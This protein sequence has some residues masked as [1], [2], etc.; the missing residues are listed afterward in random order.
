MQHRTLGRTGWKVSAIGLGTWNI[1][2]QWGPVSEDQAVDTVRAAIDAGINL[3]DTADAYGEPPGLS[4]ELV[5]RAI[6]GRRDEVYI[7][8][9]VGNFARRHGHT[10]SYE[11]PHHVRL[12]CDASLGRTK[13]DTIDLLQCHIGDLDEPDVFLEAFDQL[14]RA[15]KIRAYGV[16]TNSLKVAK[17][18]DPDPEARKGLAAVQVNYSLL[19][20]EAERDLLPWC[21]ENDVGVLVRGPLARGL[22]AG[23]YDA[24]STFSDSVRSRWNGGEGRKDY[25]RLIEQVDSLRFLSGAERTMAQ[26]ALAWLLAN[27]AVTC[28][29]P[30]AKS[31]EQARANAAAA[32]VELTDDELGQVRKALGA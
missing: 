25:L 32:D 15:G 6:A 13:I 27:P 29:I 1:G 31:P 12:C 14:E 21:R 9:K 22:L 8:T 28:P 26:A 7:A 23:K 2:G 24:D 4:E 16:S 30:G 17:A 19:N 11:T 5:G 10:L 3:I 18:F 20:R